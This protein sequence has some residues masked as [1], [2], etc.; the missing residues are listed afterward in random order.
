MLTHTLIFCLVKSCRGSAAANPARRDHKK[1]LDLPANINEL[2]QKSKCKWVKKQH[3]AMV[4][5]WHPD[6]A[7]G[8]GLFLCHISLLQISRPNLRITNTR[9]TLIMC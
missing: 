6:K 7:K 4:K 8:T 1:V 2:N 9:M 5:K 3:K